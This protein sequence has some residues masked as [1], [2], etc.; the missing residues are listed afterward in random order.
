MSE[1]AVLDMRNAVFG[2]LKRLQPFL[3]WEPP[4]QEPPPVAI[5]DHETR[6]D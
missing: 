3:G 2:I 1:Q 4:S 5:P 6:L